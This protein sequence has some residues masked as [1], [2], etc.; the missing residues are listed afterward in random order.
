MRDLHFDEG[1]TRDFNQ[2]SK[3]W[4]WATWHQVEAQREATARRLLAEVFGSPSEGE[5]LAGEHG[6]EPSE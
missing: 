4:P 5:E 2:A 1:F 6:G 3:N